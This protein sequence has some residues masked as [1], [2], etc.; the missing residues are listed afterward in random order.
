MVILGMAIQSLLCSS[1]TCDTLIA[2]GRPFNPGVPTK[3]PLWLAIN[4][5]QRGLCILHVPEWLTIGIYSSLG[6][7][8]NLIL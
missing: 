4:L 8:S 7:F 1:V 3:I 2:K 5:R 6:P